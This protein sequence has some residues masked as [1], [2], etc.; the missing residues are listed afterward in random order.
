MNT[1]NE[2]IKSLRASV[3]Q[4]QAQMNYYIIADNLQR[5][6]AD[7][8]DYNLAEEGKAASLKE[9]RRILTAMV[10]KVGLMMSC[11]DVIPFYDSLFV[12]QE[13]IDEHYDRK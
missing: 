13:N 9:M 2:N 12:T 10:G 5:K 6:A 3:R 11:S 8:K 1:K 4:L 7:C